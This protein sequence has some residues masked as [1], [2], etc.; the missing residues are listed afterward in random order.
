MPLLWMTMPFSVRQSAGSVFHLSAA[1]ATSIAR[2]VAP[3]LR[4]G[5]QC[6]RTEV[7][8]P[9]AC[10]P[11]I[12]LLKAGSAPA[13]LTL[14]LDQSASSSSATSIG[15]A[16]CTPCPIS[17]KPQI[18]VIWLS[19]P[20]RIYALGLNALAACAR[21]EALGRVKPSSSPPPASADVFRKS[22]RDALYIALMLSPPLSST[23]PH[24]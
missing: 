7:D 15:I 12:G 3:A 10:M 23:G 13:C 19:D 4:I 16:V 17:D 8:P 1:A 5:S 24:P 6:P 21:R 11:N 2:A 20:M 14:I 22:R 9:V 18:T